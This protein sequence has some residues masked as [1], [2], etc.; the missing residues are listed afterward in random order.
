MPHNLPRCCQLLANLCAANAAA[1][2]AAVDAASASASACAARPMGTGGKGHTA[3]R[4]ACANEFCLCAPL[5]A[6]VPLSL[7]LWCDQN[8]LRCCGATCSLQALWSTTIVIV[9]V[10]IVVVVTVV[11]VTRCAIAVVVAVA[12]AVTVVIAVSGITN[13]ADFVVVGDAVCT[14][15]PI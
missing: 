7:D 1:V 13:V 4:T 3:L 5:A 15:R 2:D 12:V 10:L 9:I 6:L 11:V 8:T 14:W